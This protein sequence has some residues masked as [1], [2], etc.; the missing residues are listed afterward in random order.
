MT[1]YRWDVRDRLT[2]ARLDD[3]RRITFDYDAFGRRTAKRVYFP[4]E[5]VPR[6][7]VEYGWTGNALA[8]ER[9]DGGTRTFVHVP[10]S[11]IPLLQEDAGE[12]LLCV[13]DQVGVVRELIDE[14][15]RIA[16]SDRYDAWGRLQ[17]EEA[18][19][20][21]RADG[22]TPSTPFRLLGQ[23][24]DEETGL[25]WTRFRVFDPT[26][27]RWLSP[28]PLGFRGGGNLFGFDGAPTVNVDPF[29]TTG[30]PHVHPSE[31][32]GRTPAEIDALAR[33]RGL[34]P[35]GPAPMAGRGAYVDPATN[36]AVV[37]VHPRDNLGQPPHA[38]VYNSD[39]QRLQADGSVAPS[40]ESPEAHLP[41]TLPPEDT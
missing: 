12:V 4:G 28:D 11:D 16:W 21:R 38:H 26:T 27:A 29:G 17:S 10:G 40:R 34:Q 6:R 22:R 33:E 9:S 35:R 2:E 19:P 36:S 1:E 5:D 30:D 31:V 41:I 37:E 32:V 13:T 18:N 14:S 39:G 7:E 20:Q 24:H 23:I 15:G 25:S 8:W 3:G